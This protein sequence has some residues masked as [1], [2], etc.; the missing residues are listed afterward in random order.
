MKLE[1][2]GYIIPTDSHGYLQNLFTYNNLSTEAKEILNHAVN[3]VL[4]YN[5][6]AVDSIYV[7]GS[8]AHNSYIKGY[9]DVDL[10]ILRTDSLHN[11]PTIL[12]YNGNI[13]RVDP[14]GLSMKYLHSTDRK[15]YKR[16]LLKTQSVCI[17]GLNRIPEMEGFKASK[18]TASRLS[19]K[20]QTPNPLEVAKSIP[21]Q[22]VAMKVQRISR[23]LVRGTNVLFMVP[24]QMYTRDLV[25]CYRYFCKYYPEYESQMRLLVEQVVSPTLSKEEFGSFMKNFGVKLVKMIQEAYRSE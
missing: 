10:V 20:L 16:F 15:F 6:S 9:S 1:P 5:Q 18:G 13:F 19:Q 4:E 8:F 14:G 7:R 22:E 24:E 3:L 2:Q 25:Y 17:Y 11:R 12:H 21:P 23:H